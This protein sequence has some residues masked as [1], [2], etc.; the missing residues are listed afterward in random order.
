[1]KRT[2]PAPLIGLFLIGGVA[3][4]L[5][6]LVVQSRGGFIYVPPISLAFTL[7][8]V[9]VAVV[10]LA[11]P[12][13]RK[14]TGKRKEPIDAF[15][16]ARVLALAKASS[17]AGSLL[18]GLG[19]GVLLYLLGRPIAPS[20]AILISVIAQLVSAALLIAAGLIAEWLCVLPPDDLD[21]SEKEVA[22][23]PAA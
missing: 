9:A 2:G 22:G 4:Y 12:I 23:E 5:L 10:L 8:V 14:V 13:R 21:K 19:A 18:L 3:S 11:V 15:Y 20:G 7:F 1:M 16:A 6:E 17:F